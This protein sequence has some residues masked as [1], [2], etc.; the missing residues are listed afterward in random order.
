MKKSVKLLVLVLSLALIIGALAVVAFAQDN[1][2][3]AKVGETEYTTLAEALDAVAEGGEVVLIND[4]EVSSFTVN[5]SFTINLNGNTLTATDSAN[6]A[7]TINAEVNFTVKGEGAVVTSGNLITEG[8]SAINPTVTFEGPG[9]TVVH[10]PKVATSMV[11]VMAGSYVFKN[12]DVESVAAV[13]G[14]NSI[15]ATGGS[16]SAKFT[17]DNAKITANYA[18]HVD[19][20][21][22]YMQGG[23]SVELLNSYV[24]T[25][26]SLSKYKS[27]TAEKPLY[28]KNSVIEQE[29]NDLQIKFTKEN[30]DATRKTCFLL[31][32][33][34]ELKGGAIV[35]EDSFVEFCYRLNCAGGSSTVKFVNSTLR[36]SGFTE[37]D[38]SNDTNL[39]RYAKVEFDANSV[40]LMGRGAGNITN[41]SGGDGGKVF[42]EEGFRTNAEHIV[43]NNKSFS[44][45]VMP[46]GT[47]ADVSTQY[48]FVYDPAGNLNAPYVVVDVTKEGANANPIDADVVR[49]Y[50]NSELFSANVNGYIGMDDGVNDKNV[51]TAAF[52][53]MFNMNGSFTTGGGAW[54]VG[55]YAGCGTSMLEIIGENSCYKYWVNP[56][57]TEVGGKRS[58]VGVTDATKGPNF[59]PNNA[60]ASSL[61]DNKV[62]VLDLDIATDSAAGFVSGNIELQNNGSRKAYFAIAADGT[63]THNKNNLTPNADFSIKKLDTSKW[64]RL[65]FVIYGETNTV[66]VFID[67]EYFGYGTENSNVTSI[68]SI[69][70]SA[71]KM[72]NVNA[73]LLMDNCMDREYKTYRNGDSAEN[74]TPAYYLSNL[75]MNTGV[76]ENCAVMGQPYSDIAEAM[77]TATALPGRSVELTADVDIPTKIETNGRIYTN[78]YNLAIADGSYGADVVYD[79]EGNVVYYEF[80]ETYA[81]LKV[82]YAWY[83]G[84]GDFTLDESYVFTEVKVGQVPT[85]PDSI[86]V[87]PLIQKNAAGKHLLAYHKGWSAEM[88]NTTPDEFHP[89][90]VAAAQADNGQ[91]HY[92]YPVYDTEYNDPGYTWLV[93][94]K[95]GRFVRGGTDNKLW[96]STAFSTFKLAYGETF[97]LNADFIMYGSFSYGAFATGDGSKMISLDVNGF[98]LKV[99]PLTAGSRKADIWTI[100][101]GE[102]LNV[103][104]SRAGGQIIG[105]GFM[106][107]NY[108][109]AE[110]Q[111]TKGASGGNLFQFQPSALDHASNNSTETNMNAHLNIGAYNGKGEYT[112][113][114]ANNLTCSAAS[115]VAIQSGDA[116]CSVNIDGTCFVRN[117][118]DYFGLVF[119][120]YY[121][122]KLN[123]KNTVLAS[124]TDNTVLGAYSAAAVFEE[125]TLTESPACEI[126]VDNCVILTKHNGAN[127]LSSNQAMG[128]ITFTNT[129]TNGAIK[130]TSADKQNVFVGESVHAAALEPSAFLGELTA[131]YYNKPINLRAFGI[132]ASSL[133]VQYIYA[134][135]TEVGTASAAADLQTLVYTFASTGTAL[136]GD[137]TVLGNYV[138]RTVKATDTLKVTFKGI[139]G[140][141][142]IVQEYAVGGKVIAPTIAGA[143]VGVFK[144]THDG[145]FDV[146]LPE[147]L[148]ASLTVT[149][150]VKSEVSVS[151][152]KTNLSVYS[153]FLVNLYVPAEY[154]D[155]VTKIAVGNNVLDMTDV[156]VDGVNYI[157]VA[158]AKNAEDAAKNIVFAITLKSEGYAAAVTVTVS[159][160]S[161][162]E[163]VLANENSTD[164]DKQLMYYVLNYAN[165]AAKYFGGAADATLAALLETYATVKGEKEENTY[166]DAIEE[167]ALGQVFASASVKLTSA[168]AFV[169]TLKD[170]FAGTVT[171]TY[172]D[173][174]RTY[175]VT[176]DSDREIVVTGMKAY[177]F[178]L[179]ITVNAEGTIGEESVATENA[180][181]NLDTFVKYH[182]ES[183]AAESVACEDLLV[184]LYDYVVCA[185][186][187]V[188]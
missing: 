64:H 41:G 67:G 61:T 155:Y 10:D 55:E 25:S 185:K 158:I 66:H 20:C 135:P 28:V 121:Y 152:I 146:E 84:I 97:V 113:A 24:K 132:P 180:Q 143:D 17:F 58:T 124:V 159:V 137:G 16:A 169:L 6:A 170:G 4:A 175:V 76:V 174:T 3:V 127:I 184:A 37:N 52:C 11:S 92:V 147:V 164:A 32:W 186:A 70:Y 181:Y 150:G 87:S 81:S 107:V 148:T 15:F 100:K 44:N 139:G 151:G 163:K 154:K 99:S 140:N 126:V 112:A 1:G 39:L 38:S 117:S 136:D 173:K 2:A 53:K 60:N 86:N 131:A 168:P 63:L 156:V 162:A 138:V 71:D 133:S 142:D 14:A 157:K 30:N 74:Q 111:Q 5:K 35:I 165:E 183:E 98:T 119:T 145:T 93:I 176:A 19:D 182:V 27:S 102:T 69:R 65:S 68:N 149:P 94:D 141:E 12:V 26:G 48:K 7:F 123:I 83:N 59:L 161:Y 88:D 13:S 72:Q 29:F 125:G 50:D 40:Y 178:C 95:D 56:N 75:P 153:D 128:S 36:H 116:T 110:T 80:D 23:A 120:R 85:A 33:G 134:E 166:A 9:L 21:I 122:G 179:N 43:K 42:V 105:E 129:Y 108:N 18:N 49:F 106:D 90:T 54:N 177:N 8:N 45:F 89:L 22:I 187:Y 115:V 118:S 130:A 104:S 101:N 62:V 96:S 188:G 51:T 109:N 114:Y 144:L 167:L 171:V 160:A 79:N 31:G 46:D 78:G 103:F 73:T 34:D 47:T 172:G 91:P 77:T 82:T 57:G